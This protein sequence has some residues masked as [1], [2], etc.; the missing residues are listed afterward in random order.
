MPS[1]ID[2]WLSSIGA[3]DSP[4]KRLYRYHCKYEDE[5]Y[6]KNI[7]RLSRP[8]DKVLIIDYD[9][10]IYAQTPDNGLEAAWSG[11]EK[12][13]KLVDLTQILV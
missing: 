4:H 8:L 9:H 13:Q 3:F 11:S 6:K 5:I 7:E 12:D 10:R 1:D 2:P